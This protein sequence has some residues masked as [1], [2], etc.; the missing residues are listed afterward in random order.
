MLEE[1]VVPDRL[2]ALVAVHVGAVVDGP[3]PGV[4][5]AGVES[6][7]WVDRPHRVVVGLVLLGVAFRIGVADLEVPP[8]LVA[9][10]PPRHV[11]RFRIA[12]FGPERAHLGVGRAVDVL[13]PLG[14][15]LRT[16]HRPERDS[17]VRLDVGEFTEPEPLVRSH[18]VRFQ[19][20]PVDDRHDR[21]VLDRPDT[22]LPVIVV[23]ETPA[24]PSEYRDVEF[25]EK[26]DRVHT[27]AVLGRD[28]IVVLADPQTAIDASAEVF[29]EVSVDVFVDPVDR[30]LSV[31]RD[32]RRHTGRF[33]EGI[34]IMISERPTVPAASIGRNGQYRW[35]RKFKIVI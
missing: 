13:D 18:V 16:G 4:H 28:A 21:P 14:G 6:A 3:Q 17:E 22:V 20:A 31:D 5:G 24:R 8:D 10:P 25:L 35:Q 34:L 11:P 32:C 23:G 9:D 30:I 12:V 27:D 15:F 2:L 29:S 1:Y 26:F 7:V 19:P 33:F